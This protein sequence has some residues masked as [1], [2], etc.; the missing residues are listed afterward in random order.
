[1]RCLDS[2]VGDTRI[3]NLAG[4]LIPEDFLLWSGHGNTVMRQNIPELGV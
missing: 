2:I 4:I 1:M 3:M